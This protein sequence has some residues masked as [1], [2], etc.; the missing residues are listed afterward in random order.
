MTGA[1]WKSAPDFAEF[2]EALGVKTTQIVTALVAGPTAGVIYSPDDTDHERVVLIGLQRD[3]DG[4]YQVTNAPKE[5]PGFFDGLRENVE[6]HLKD[7]LGEPEE[8]K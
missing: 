8:E 1:E 5:L 6:R 7:E 2:A 3:D 4:I